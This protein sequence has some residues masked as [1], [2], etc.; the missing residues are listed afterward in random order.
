MK[1]LYIVLSVLSISFSFLHTSAAA[2]KKSTPK[3]TQGLDSMPGMSMDMSNSSTGEIKYP[4]LKID[5]YSNI[6]YRYEK[7]S[8]DVDDQ[9]NSFGLGQVVLFFNSDLQEKLHVT[10]EIAFE[11][12]S[13]DNEPGIDIE[14]MIMTYDVSDALK[15]S[16]GR[17]HAPISY[18]NIIYHHAAWMRTSVE[19]P[20]LV[21]FEDDAGPLPIHLVG[22]NL[23]GTIFNGAV[24][25]MD[26]NFGF[27]NGRGQKTTEVTNAFDHNAFKA[28]DLMLLFSP[29]AIDGLSFGPIG[30]FD[31]V[32]PNSAP[33]ADDLADGILARANEMN[34]AITGGF[35]VY[36]HK[37][38]EFLSE[39]DYIWHNDRGG[40]GTFKNYGAYAQIGYKFDKLTPY[41]Q[42]DYLNYAAGDTF[43]APNVLDLNGYHAGL[44]W[45]AF[46]FAALK[47]EYEIKDEQTHSL[48]HAGIVDASFHF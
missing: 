34:E 19:R 24:L 39:F 41:F 23:T 30:W 15:I 27:G 2:E 44:R 22:L 37:H 11:F 46:N 14:R 8:K 4:N 38:I 20:D 12:S 21:A 42:Y 16:V 18:W 26:Y 7:A 5:G 6:G 1:K 17:F 40:G 48:V 33:S 25:K 3:K 10:S 9:S 47:F 32:P 13:T 35:L 36:N 45:D 28:F 31:R 29:A 43:Y